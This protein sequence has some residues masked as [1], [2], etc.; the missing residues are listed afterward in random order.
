LFD[1][2][3]LHEYHV[4]KE[5]ITKVNIEIIHPQQSA[6]GAIKWEKITDINNLIN[7][8][9]SNIKTKEIWPHMPDSMGELKMQI[10]QMVK[11]L[12]VTEKYCGPGEWHGSFKEALV[13][14]KKNRLPKGFA[15]A[16]GI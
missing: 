10:I 9:P 14:V 15:I 16:L 13:L 7:N 12:K 1:H 8:L 2:K 11:E 4:V 5:I 6:I 3:I